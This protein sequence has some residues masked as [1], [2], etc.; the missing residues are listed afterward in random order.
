M[1]KRGPD[2][3]STR[4]AF[5]QERHPG[6]SV[7]LPIRLHVEDPL[8]TWGFGIEL[9]LPELYLSGHLM[10]YYAPGQR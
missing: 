4:R 9:E 7:F 10:P 2:T 6:L 1:E 5:P 8:E 3:G